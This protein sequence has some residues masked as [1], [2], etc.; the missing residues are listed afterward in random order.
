M[1]SVFM[2]ICSALDVSNELLSV[3][4]PNSNFTCWCTGFILQS[5]TDTSFQLSFADL[6]GY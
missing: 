6:T 5:K 3:S 4:R 1:P 2:A